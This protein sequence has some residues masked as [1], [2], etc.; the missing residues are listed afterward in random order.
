[1]TETDEREYFKK[2]HDKIISCFRDEFFSWIESAKERNVTEGDVLVMLMN[3]TI[4]VSS[5]I[6]GTIRMYLPDTRIDFDFI[7]AKM[8]N[9]M[10]DTFE[11]VKNIT[12]R[13]DEENEHLH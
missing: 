2:I 4:S 5:G 8:I 3:L 6:Y 12:L 7:R 11:K 10:S 1:M 13:T 9:E